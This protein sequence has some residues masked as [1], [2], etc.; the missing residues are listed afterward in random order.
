M[1]SFDEVVKRCRA[2]GF[3][4]MK[5]AREA[6]IDKQTLKLPF[7]YVYERA[8]LSTTLYG[9]QIYPESIREALLEKDLTPTVTGRATLVTKFDDAH[10]QYLEVHV[11]LRKSKTG[12]TVLAGKIEAEII[13]VL[14]HKNA[15]YRELASYLGD[16]AKP[17]IIFWP[18]EDPQYF[19]PDVKQKWVVKAA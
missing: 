11:E 18:H 19:R 8:D 17:R 12:S 5:E 14:K 16:R 6:G 10:N 15:E 4:L 1:L 7:V 9:L 3:D 2:H 13:K